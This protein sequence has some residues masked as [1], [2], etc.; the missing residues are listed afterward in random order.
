VVVGNWAAPIDDGWTPRILLANYE[1]EWSRCVVGPFA[2]DRGNMTTNECTPSLPN[3]V[4]VAEVRRIGV[5]ELGGNRRLAAFHGLT[6]VGVRGGAPQ[7]RGQDHRHSDHVAAAFGH[8]L[9]F[10]WSS[11]RANYQSLGARNDGELPRVVGDDVTLF[12]RHVA[13]ASN[14]DPNEIVEYSW[15]KGVV[16]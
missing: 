13:T 4:N 16:D 15:P 2:A 7:W 14:R 12:E 9:W 1:N 3:E 6:V 8:A 10:P 11:A 5:A